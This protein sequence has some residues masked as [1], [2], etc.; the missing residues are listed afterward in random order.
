MTEVSL[1]L[2]LKSPLLWLKTLVNLGK[3]EYTDDEEN[4][5]RSL[6]DYVDQYLPMRPMVKKFFKK[7]NSLLHKNDND[8]THDSYQSIIKQG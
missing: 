3:S 1:N 2:F 4:A 6:V 7:V 8:L 5:L